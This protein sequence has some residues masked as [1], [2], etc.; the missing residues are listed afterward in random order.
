[1]GLASTLDITPQQRQLVRALLQEYLPETTVWAYGS[2]VKG[3]AR[4]HSDLDLVAFASAQQQAA[5]A[6]LKDAFDESDLPFRVDLFAWH[7]IP[8]SFHRTIAA[9]HSV[10]Q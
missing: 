2:R 5:I 8:K 1:M 10:L 7:E 3:T 4:P 6:E 9:A